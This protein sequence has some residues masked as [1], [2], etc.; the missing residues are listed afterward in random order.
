MKL[1]IP[2]LSAAALIALSGP[3]LAAKNNSINSTDNIEF[4]NTFNCNNSRCEL[5]CTPMS[6]APYK[7]ATSIVQ[8]RMIGYKSGTIKF[9]LE[10]NGYKYSSVLIPAGTESCQL[11]NLSNS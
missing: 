6:G 2:L 4:Q 1:H 7:K 3:A 5:I 10:H 8:G 9:N 11:T